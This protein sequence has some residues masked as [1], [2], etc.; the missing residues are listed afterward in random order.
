[1]EDKHK[2]SRFLD[3]QN[4][5]YL[6]ALSEI[7]NGRKQSHWMW[8]VFPQIKGLGQSTISKHY[9]INDLEEAESYLAHP[10]L[11]KHLIEISGELVKIDGKSATD[12]LGSPDDMKLRSS[13]TLFMIVKNT[14]PVFK[15]VLDKYFSGAL[16]EMT[17]KIVAG[18][19]R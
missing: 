5:V 13:M 17:L 1:M 19:A 16:D 4:Q 10:V 8:F 15:Q 3:A 6:N 12:I 18:Y 7:R 9:G 14:N 2:L 11:G